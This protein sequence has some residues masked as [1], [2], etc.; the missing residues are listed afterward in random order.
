[1]SA[2]RKRVL[3]SSDLLRRHCPAKGGGNC[4]LCKDRGILN[5]VSGSECGTLVGRAHKGLKERNV[6]NV[7]PEALD[8]GGAVGEME[9]G[10]EGRKKNADG[11]GNK[12]TKG[13]SRKEKRRKK[14]VMGRSTV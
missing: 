11:C 13:G 2:R 7:V 6:W 9:E 1:M 12:E 8:L 4:G 5:E 10:K 14:S 3:R